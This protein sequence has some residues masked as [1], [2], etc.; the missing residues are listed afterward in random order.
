M[1]S[2]SV[3]IDR[4]KFAWKPFLNNGISLRMAFFEAAGKHT[5]KELIFT[6]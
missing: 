5:V 1:I 2:Y 6:R 4:V 3:D